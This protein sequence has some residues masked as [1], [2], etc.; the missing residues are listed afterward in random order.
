M[1]LSL[2]WLFFGV[3]FELKKKMVGLLATILIGCGSGSV[4]QSVGVSFIL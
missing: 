4:F 3:M 2:F 1:H